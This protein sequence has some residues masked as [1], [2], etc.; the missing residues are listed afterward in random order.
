MLPS[1]T[2]LLPCTFSPAS[3]FRHRTLGS[4]K[5]NG[6]HPTYFTVFQNG[7]LPPVIRRH[8]GFKSTLLGDKLG[9]QLLHS[10]PRPTAQASDDSRAVLFRSLSINACTAWP[11]QFRWPGLPLALQHST[12]WLTSCLRNKTARGILFL[13]DTPLTVRVAIVPTS[14]NMTQGV[15]GNLN[16]V[17]GPLD[18]PPTFHIHLFT[19]CGR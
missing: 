14:R 8:L 17:R 1:L 11:G 3:I 13:L 19:V 12:A 16:A 7:S 4:K 2:S 9:M 10:L 15:P 5:Y 6:V 18:S